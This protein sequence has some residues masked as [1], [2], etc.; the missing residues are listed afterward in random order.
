MDAR[1]PL[2]WENLPTYHQFYNDLVWDG[3]LPMPTFVLG[4]SK[5]KRKFV[6][7][8]EYH[9]T[10]WGTGC[11]LIDPT[12]CED[13]DAMIATLLHEMIHQWQDTYAFRLDHRGLFKGWCDHIETLT[14]F[15]P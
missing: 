6:A 9:P 4:A 3:T 7:M 8:G 2:T 13:E 5:E 10:G 1:L 11:I 15:A 14:G 12:A